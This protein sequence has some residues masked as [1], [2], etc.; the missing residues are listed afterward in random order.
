[1]PAMLRFSKDIPCFW[2]TS[3]HP[4]IKRPQGVFEADGESESNFSQGSK[5][6]REGGEIHRCILVV[7]GSGLIFGHTV[8][9]RNP[10][11]PWMVETL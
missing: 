5:G 11:P 10:A 3:T 6:V 2:A 1:M 7:G 8:D 9:G 4:K